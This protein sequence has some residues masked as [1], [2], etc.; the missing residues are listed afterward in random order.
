ME[1]SAEKRAGSNERSSKP[2]VVLDVEE[3]VVVELSDVAFADDFE[4][5]S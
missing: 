3:G 4:L 5:S 1:E 2:F